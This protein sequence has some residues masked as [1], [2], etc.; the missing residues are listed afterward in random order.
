MIEGLSHITFIVSDLERM[1]EFLEVVFD[2]EQVYA[3]GDETFSLSRE[4]FF[5]IGPVWVAVMEGD[6]LP[7]RTYNHIAFKISDRE[8]E[9]YARRVRSLG[10]KVREGRSRVEGEGRSL[11]FHDYD[12]HLF[13]LHTGT[14]AQRLERYE[15]GLRTV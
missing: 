15:K 5:M 7:E 6:S 4:M 14:L 13:E 11:Y 8:F 12:N 1:K 2:A 10:V 9:A 3:S